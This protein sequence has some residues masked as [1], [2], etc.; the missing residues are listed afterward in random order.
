MRERGEGRVGH[1]S[2]RRSQHGWY[3]DYG[4]GVREERSIT[5]PPHLF[6]SVHHSDRTV[7]KN[8]R[9]LWEVMSQLFREREKVRKR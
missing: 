5:S 1:C 9:C 3:R 4:G 2:G 6:L 8:R 7:E